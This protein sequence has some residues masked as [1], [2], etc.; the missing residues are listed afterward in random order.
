MNVRYLGALLQPV[1]RRNGWQIANTAANFDNPGHG[2]NVV[3]QVVAVGH[4]LCRLWWTVGWSTCRVQNCG[5]YPLL[6]QLLQTCPRC[7]ADLRLGIGEG[8]SV[9]AHTFPRQRRCS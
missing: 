6:A 9:V 2:T 7:S 5:R 4:T 8:V 3:R 1:E